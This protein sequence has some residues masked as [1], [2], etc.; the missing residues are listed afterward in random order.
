MGLSCVFL[1]KEEYFRRIGVKWISLGADGLPLV[2]VAAVF[3]APVIPAIRRKLQKT[4]TGENIIGVAT[5]ASNIVIL[6]VASLLL[7]N[8]T[9]AP[10][11]YWHF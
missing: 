9:N 11:L 4:D 3:S 2:L 5:V 1:A 10:F 8:S 6:L 7:V